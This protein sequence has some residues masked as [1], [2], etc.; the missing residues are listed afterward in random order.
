MKFSEVVAD[1][2]SKGYTEPD[3]RDDLNGTDVARKVGMRGWED[4]GW[5][6]VKGTVGLGHWKWSAAFAC[7]P[8][9][10]HHRSHGLS[11]FPCATANLGALPI[12]A[13]HFFVPRLFS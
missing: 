1:A 10:H 11:T 3:P 6:V 4:R 9:R 13:A 2:R 12:A 7:V 5:R 8:V